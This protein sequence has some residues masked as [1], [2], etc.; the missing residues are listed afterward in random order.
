MNKEEFKEYLNNLNININDEIMNQLDIYYK[1]L[2]EYNSHTNL[3]AI[4]E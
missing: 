3:T 1:Y 2:V 4:T